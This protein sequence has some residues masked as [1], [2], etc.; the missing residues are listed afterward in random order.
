MKEF[1]NYLVSKHLTSKKESHFYRS[2][3]KNLYDFIGK[4]PGSK[5]ENEDI[6]QYINYITKSK[7]E[8]QVKQAQEAIRIYLYYIN[9]QKEAPISANSN[10]KAQW[11]L[12]G[13]QMVNMLRLKQLSLQTE[14]TYMTWLRDFYRFIRGRSPYLIDGSHV[15]NYLT[16]LAVDRHVASSTQNQALNALLFFF[17]ICP[18]KGSWEHTGCRT[19]KTKAQ[20]SGCSHPTGN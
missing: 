16:Y 9:Q 1:S 3:V 4:N 11:K 20:A 8:W 10:L 6:D 2:W 15:K 7:Q 14:R 5:L 13:S 19:G 18:R 17:P 12:V